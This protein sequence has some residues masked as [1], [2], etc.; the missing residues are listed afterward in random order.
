M[1]NKKL[2]IAFGQIWQEQNTFCPIKTNISDFKQNGLFFGKEIIDRFTGINEIGGFIKAAEDF[3][4]SDVEL[5]PT[6][7]VWAWPKGNVTKAAYKEIKKELISYLKKN[8]P[9]DGV[10]LSL[11]GSMVSDEVFDVEGDI[12]E[13]IHNE[14]SENLPIA[15]S[16]DLHANIT[17]KMLKNTV[18]I[19]GYH[20][21]PHMD[22]FRTGYKAAEVF[23]DILCGKLNLERGFV[24]I[25]MVTPARLHNTNKGPFKKVFDYLGKIENEKNAVSASFFSVQPWLD[26]PELGWSTLVYF[27]PNSNNLKDST[28]NVQVND[29][30]KYAE[31]ISDLAWQLRREFFTKETPPY[32]AIQKASKMEKGLMVISDSDSTLS[33]GTGDNTCIL[34]ELIKQNI[35]FP[36]LL[37]VVDKEVVKQA[38]KTGV[39]GIITCKIGAKMD[40][41]FSKTLKI[42][43]MV[44][45]ITDGK[46]VTDGH[47]GKNYVDMGKVVVLEIGSIIVLVS[48][49]IGPVFELNVFRNAGLEPGNFRVVVVKS[50]VGFR[51]AYEPIAD[52]IV[53]ADCPGL[54]SS[55][56][57]IFTFENIPHPIFPFDEISHWRNKNG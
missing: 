6:I 31:K 14:L 34:S 24:K 43:A 29:A 36:A 16:L 10:L 18:F 39:G 41:I 20:T 48:E 54:T 47:A 3:K 51:N 22:L 55:N 33:G 28:G 7:R 53:L 45:N 25:P 27:Q 11:H 17:E 37:T 30:Q 4:N 21:C 2:R 38:L 13:T 56:L 19:E 15:I 12:L 42:T 5:I 8:L 44:K 50:P 9:I 40:K 35:K 32:I 26:V 23:F 49:K 57:N 46:F 52:E 1:A